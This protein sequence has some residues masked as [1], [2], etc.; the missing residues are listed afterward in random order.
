MAAVSDNKKSNENS[1]K[2]TPK[3][4]ARMA[5]AAVPVRANARIG[6]W[7][8]QVNKASNIKA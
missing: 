5:P 3:C 2:A 8:G 4:S 7:Q 6:T 1:P